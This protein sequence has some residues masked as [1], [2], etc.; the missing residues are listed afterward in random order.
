M[1]EIANQSSPASARP[2]RDPRAD[3][4]R[5]LALWMIV[6]DHTPG[7]WLSGLTIKNFTLSDATEVFVLLAGYAAAFAY[8]GQADRQGWAPAAAALVR[9]VSKLYV[10]H[11]F[12]LVVFTAQVGFSAATLDRAIYLDELA[13]DPFAEQPYRT[14]LEA[15]LLR[16]QPA[17]LDILPLYIVLLTMLIPGLV[18]RP[19]PWLMLGLSLTLWLGARALGVNF[20]RWQEG[21]W[22][23][24]P[25]AW[26][27]LFVLGFLLGQ[28]VRGAPSIALPP[29]SGWSTGAALLL[30]GLGLAAMF[31][32]D[33]PGM[34]EGWPLW[35]PGF[36]AGIDKTSLHPLRLASI[37]ALAYLVAAYVPREGR[38]LR[39][40]WME[41]FAMMGR[42]SLPVFCF[43]ILLSF[44]ARLML[45]AGDGWAMQVAVNMLCLCALILVGWVAEWS[46]G[47]MRPREPALPAATVLSAPL[48]AR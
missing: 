20:P 38:F 33:R 25:L 39:S 5:G 15:L 44:L 18:M 14:L 9:R 17:F 36:L 22:F 8:A 1:S 34:M 31:A 40:V 19:W 41:P 42:H 11:I 45:E 2:R 46:R 6:V 4:C 7:N 48:E 10:A 12:L 47:T 32:S 23:F 28:S 43:G 13:L 24:N 16:F 3:L 35:V 30:L 21:G 27:V 29:R 37:I 26:Q